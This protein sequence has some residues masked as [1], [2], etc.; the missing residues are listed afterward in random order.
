MN[1]KEPTTF[2]EQANLLKEKNIYISDMASCIDFLSKTNYY[3]LA[4]YYLPFIDKNTQKCFANIDFE[5]VQN[6]YL[7]DAK[8]RNLIS[9][10]IETIE[11]Y[12]RTQLSYYHAHSYGAEGY[13]KSSSFNKR[14]NHTAFK[15]HI[16]QCIDEKNINPIFL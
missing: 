5:R 3:R 10:A 12:I 14:H 7:F 11:V 6:I 16:N 9:S 8:L 15:N 2:Q 13:M 4:G 1:L